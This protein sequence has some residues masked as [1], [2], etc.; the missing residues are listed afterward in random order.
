MLDYGSINLLQNDQYILCIVVYDIRDQSHIDVEGNGTRACP[1]K[2]C[3]DMT[4]YALAN[5]SSRMYGD[6]GPYPWIASR[7]YFHGRQ[8]CEIL[9]LQ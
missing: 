9:P 8:T 4:L 6:G 2:S 3:V 7:I 5:C 1:S